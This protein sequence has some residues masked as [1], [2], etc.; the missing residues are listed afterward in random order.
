VAARAAALRCN[1]PP[2][3][4]E[5]DLRLNAVRA[6]GAEALAAALSGNA[7][8]SKVLLSGN[9]LEAEAA[10]KIDSACGDGRLQLWEPGWVPAPIGTRVS[11]LGI[12]SEAHALAAAEAPT[13]ARSTWEGGW[14]NGGGTTEAQAAAAAAAEGGVRC[15]ASAR[16]ALLLRALLAAIALGLGAFFAA[17]A[18][19]RW[20]L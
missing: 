2:P 14:Y 13:W 6:A 5:L 11:A 20:I 16:S 7:L 12:E 15:R 17:A 1:P 3:L 19:R 8:V 9:A 10:L 18:Y 4:Q